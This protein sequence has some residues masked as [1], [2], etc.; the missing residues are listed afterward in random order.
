MNFE[1]L[2]MRSLFAV[3]MLVC[4]LVMGAMVISSPIPTDNVRLAGNNKL[5]LP[6]VCAVQDGVICP[7]NSH[8]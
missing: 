1:T 7:R 2:M 6:A 3:C 5:T 8:G 4:T